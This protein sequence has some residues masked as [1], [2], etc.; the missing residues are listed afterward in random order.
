[1]SNA[2]WGTRGEMAEAA[3]AEW[4]GRTA[5]RRLKCTMGERVGRYFCSERDMG[6]GRE[7]EAGLLDR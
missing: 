2:G 6:R 3:N 4:G 1:V 5:A 7:E